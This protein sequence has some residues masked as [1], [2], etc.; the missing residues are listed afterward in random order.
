MKFLNVP[1]NEEL[2]VKLKIL[3]AK[4]KSTIEKI[5]DEA[6]GT[7]DFKVN[8]GTEWKISVPMERS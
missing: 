6:K 7:I 8:N 2:H 5:I 1:I 3:T 4:K